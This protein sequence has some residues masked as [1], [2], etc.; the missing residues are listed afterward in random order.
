MRVLQ[1]DLH[2][3]I[4]FIL[5]PEEVC[6]ISLRVCVCVA[7]TPCSD[8]SEALARGGGGRELK[9]EWA[10]FH[11]Y[12]NKPATKKRPHQEKHT[13]SVA[14]KI[15]AD[16]ADSLSANQ[17]RV[18][19]THTRTGAH[20]GRHTTLDSRRI[21]KHKQLS[22]SRS[23]RLSDQLILISSKANNGRGSGDCVGPVIIVCSYTTPVCPLGSLLLQPH[24]VCV[25]RGG[26]IVFKG[27]IWRL[28]M[29]T[30]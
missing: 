8:L 25:C 5:R 17:H 20:R 11:K 15:C 30:V 3:K 23:L 6:R 2:L 4:L 22:R 18:T 14:P 12:S 19:H 13:A 29:S 10:S 1:T 9:G 21:N 26:D 27:A 28:L 24:L 16:A 7:Y